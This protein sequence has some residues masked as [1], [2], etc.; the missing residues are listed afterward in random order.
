[1]SLDTDFQ[2]LIIYFK[3][4]ITK[5]TEYQTDME[6]IDKRTNLENLFKDLSKNTLNLHGR[7][8]PVSNNLELI[9]ESKHN[10]R[11]ILQE[12][13]DKENVEMGQLLAESAGND[14]EIQELEKLT[15][16]AKKEYLVEQKKLNDYNNMIRE[17]NKNPFLVFKYMGKKELWEA[18]AVS[19]GACNKKWSEYKEILAQLNNRRKQLDYA[20]TQKSLYQDLINKSQIQLKEVDDTVTDVT[21]QISMFNDAVGSFIDIT[22]N[23]SAVKKSTDNGK[24]V[25]DTDESLKILINGF[26]S[27]NNCYAL[28]TKIVNRLKEIK[29]KSCYDQVI[30]KIT[31]FVQQLTDSAEELNCEIMKFDK[32]LNPKRTILPIKP[33]LG[34][35]P[36]IKSTAAPTIEN[37]TVNIDEQNKLVNTMLKNAGNIIK[38]FNLEDN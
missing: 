1:M 15:D 37:E 36:I 8:K 25:I 38:T 10:Q 30:T 6:N 31:T 28:F 4:V 26:N 23:I 20:F 16:A 34:G 32:A 12:F 14:T 35:I 7:L 33:P 5:T 19:M 9:V 18:V 2:A 29:N 27:A 3:D 21:L 24:Y 11:G 13:I 17:I 22:K